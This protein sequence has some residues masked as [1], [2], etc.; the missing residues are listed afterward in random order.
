MLFSL[1]SNNVSKKKNKQNPTLGSFNTA[2]AEW[3]ISKTLPN[4]K[5]RQDFNTFW[6]LVDTQKSQVL[7]LSIQIYP[8]TLT[9]D[10]LS[11]EISCKNSYFDMMI[12]LVS[13]R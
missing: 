4:P 2:E 1:Y 13:F 10:I 12:T 5:G 8:I 6:E 9:P 7:Y 11:P 3:N